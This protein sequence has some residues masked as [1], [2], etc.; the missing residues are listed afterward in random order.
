M[1]NKRKKSE[2]NIES[3]KGK[4]LNEYIQLTN[5]TNDIEEEIQYFKGLD[6]SLQENFIKSLKELQKKS[7]FKK[8]YMIRLL[9][10]N[11]PEEYKK[12]LYRKLIN[13]QQGNNSKLLYW[14][15]SFLRIPFETYN[16]IPI[17]YN[18]DNDIDCNLY[19]EESRQKLQ[20]CTYGMNEAKNQ[21]IELLG[22]WIV[23]PS[24][25][26]SCI[27][28]KGPMG[29]GKT[30]FIKNGI[31]QILKRPFSLIQLGGASDASYLNGHSYTYEGSTYG[32]IVDILIQQKTMN[33]IIFFDELDKV[34]HTEQGQEISGILTHITDPSQNNVFIDKYFSEIT[35]DLSKCLFI[36]SYN[37]EELV[38]PILKDRMTVINI[39]GYNNE[40]KFNIVK[41]YIIP[42]IEKEFLLQNEI[43]WNDTTIIQI[44]SLFYEEEGVRNLK[45]YIYKIYSKINLLR[46]TIKK[47]IF[48]IKI[49]ETYLGTFQ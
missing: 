28:L 22:K 4:Y 30:T 11:I 5:D 31:S 16:K 41:Y 6:P 49:D 20:E 15:D 8:P 10:S 26:N 18:Y 17:T 33:P 12:V 44:I 46:F 7:D 14:I 43:I 29:T 1:S 2:R 24:S 47:D 27:A 21:I 19:L 40:E 45:R 13:L 34:S 42:E 25:I 48:P 36:F 39:K 32:K 23:N 9:E 37:N 38:N 3:K 35:F